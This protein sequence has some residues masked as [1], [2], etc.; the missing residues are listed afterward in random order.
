VALPALIQLAVVAFIVTCAMV[1]ESV[2]FAEARR[3]V[4]AELAKH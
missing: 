1:V 2:L 3:K 4:R